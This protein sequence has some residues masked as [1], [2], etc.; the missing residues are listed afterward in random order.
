[1]LVPQSSSHR[2]VLFGDGCWANIGGTIWTGFFFGSVLFYF[3]F[4]VDEAPPAQEQSISRLM[5]IQGDVLS[6][7]DQWR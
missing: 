2:S 3:P 1:M 7:A 6:S 5:G 4:L